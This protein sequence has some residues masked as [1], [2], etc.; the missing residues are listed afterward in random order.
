[1]IMYHSNQ[2]V[3]KG[4]KGKFTTKREVYHVVVNFFFLLAACRNFSYDQSF[5]PYNETGNEKGRTR[6]CG[7]TASMWRCQNHKTILHKA[8]FGIVLK[9][10]SIFLFQYVKDDRFFLYSK[11]IKTTQS[12]WRPYKLTTFEEYCMQAIH[13]SQR[14]II[15]PICRA[16]GKENVYTFA[17][18]C[19]DKIKNRSHS[20]TWK[21]SAKNV[22][23]IVT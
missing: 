20:W 7:Y 11:T 3:N 21:T 14:C 1:M 19:L 8:T 15:K 17:D 2:I 4:K 13:P 16:V 5:L 10:P 18:N 22:S 12:I 23:G 9:W 6:N